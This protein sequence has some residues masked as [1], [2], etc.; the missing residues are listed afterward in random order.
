MSKRT[1]VAHL[2][3]L[4]TRSEGTELDIIALQSAGKSPFH[5]EPRY[6]ILA[7]REIV[8]LL[9]FDIYELVEQIVTLHQEMSLD[10]QDGY[11]HVFKFSESKF[12]ALYNGE[13]HF[14]IR[15]LVAVFEYDGTT[16]CTLKKTCFKC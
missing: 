6:G 1:L 12:Y 9:I 7:L 3:I 4:G 11:F 14:Q 10:V 2:G 8:S 13:K 5:G 16:Y 15:G